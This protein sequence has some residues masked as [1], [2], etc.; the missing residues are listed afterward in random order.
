M[1]EVQ[2]TR[3]KMYRGQVVKTLGFFYPDPMTVEDLKG[4]LIA[5]GISITADTVKVLHY[6]ADKEY[7]RIKEGGNSEFKD[8]DIVHLTAKGI[9]L[10]EA[11]IIDP[12]VIL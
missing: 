7:I 2:T 10:I 11:T 5:R 4:A 3:N 1:D 6:L 8:D 12:G 9:D